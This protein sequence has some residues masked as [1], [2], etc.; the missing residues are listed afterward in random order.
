MLSTTRRLDILAPITSRTSGRVNVSLQAAGRTTKFSAPVDSK[1]ARV[2][3][4][5]GIPAVQARLRTGILTIAYPGDADTQPQLVGL[6][7]R[8]AAREP[9]RGTAEDRQR[10]ADRQRAHLDPRAWF[11]A[12]AAALRAR[13]P[14]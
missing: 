10:A 1:R 8:R 4:D 7:C 11:G 12:A 14:A 2:R 5:R 9:E 3:I 13:R 6:A